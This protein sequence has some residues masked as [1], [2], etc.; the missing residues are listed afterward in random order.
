MNK[1]IQYR[2]LKKYKY[3]L[4]APYQYNVEI[5]PGRV[6]ETEYLKLDI[7]GLLTIKC[8]YA[9]DGASGPAIDTD[10]FMRGSLVHDALYQMIKLKLISSS[11]RKKADK[12]LMKIC[13][14]DGMIKIRAWWVY[15]A[16]RFFGGVWNW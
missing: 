10:S 2:E 9:W 13:L 7:D 11:F 14:E 16:V 5:Y 12:I 4:T 8:W 3:Q 15:R 6:K 1:K